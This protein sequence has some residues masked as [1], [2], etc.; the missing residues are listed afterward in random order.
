MAFYALKDV[1]KDVFEGVEKRFD[2]KESVTTVPTG[3][4]DIDL[5]LSGL[6]RSNLIVIAGRPNMGT[7][8]LCL[9]IAAHAAIE[10][11]IPAAVLSLDLTKE[12]VVQRMLSSES[13]VSLDKMKT[14]SLNK[15]DWGRLTTAVGRLYEAPVYVDDTPVRRT[16]RMDRTMKQLKELK[17]NSGIKL[18]IVDYLQLFA[19]KPGENHFAAAESLKNTAK[20]LNVPVVAVSQLQSF[21]DERMDYRPALSD[22]RRC[23]LIVERYADVV[24]FV[25]R[26]SMYNPCECPREEC[27][28]GKRNAMEVIVEKNRNGPVGRVNLFFDWEIVR[29]E[30]I[31]GK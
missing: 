10:K 18:V 6:Q 30:N 14:G 26:D 22:L 7:T 15:E 2:K 13:R 27:S 17:R 16:D 11:K 25:Y 9:N 31:P 12:E 3:F 5:L 29:L 8:A 4:H 28:C 19:E 20:A 21:A 24:M 1:I 23:D